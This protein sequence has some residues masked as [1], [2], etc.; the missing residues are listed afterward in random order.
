MG[1]TISG[2]PGPDV[3]TGNG[4]IGGPVFGGFG[5]DT[6]DLPGATSIDCGFGRDSYGVYEGQTATRCERPLPPP[7]V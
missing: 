1:L 5:N 7:S 4:A 6:I 3:I 2:G